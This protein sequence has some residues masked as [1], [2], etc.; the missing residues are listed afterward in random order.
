MDVFRLVRHALPDRV[1][2]QLKGT[3][4]DDVYRSKP[5]KSIR[6]RYAS[7]QTVTYNTDGQEVQLAVP[8][9]PVEGATDDQEYEPFLVKELSKELDSESVLYNVGAGYGF[10]VRLGERLGVPPEQ[11][12]AFEGDHFRLP[13]L[14]R[15]IPEATSLHEEFVSDNSVEGQTTLDEYASSAVDPTTILIDVEGAELA[16]LKGATELFSRKRPVVYVEVH[17]NSM[18]SATPAEVIELGDSHG[19]DVSAANHRQA[20]SEWQPADP[21]ALPLDHSTPHPTCLVRFR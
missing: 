9:D 7:L 20:E 2:R 5:V 16:V 11:I 18:N 6:G 14:Q 3:F 13:I 21:E 15:N 12:H 4:I 19:Y 10:Y 17:P 8:A 1:R